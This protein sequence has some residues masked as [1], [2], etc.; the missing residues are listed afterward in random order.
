MSTAS[1]TQTGGAATVA[2]TVSRGLQGVQGIQGE[3]GPAG[4]TDYTLLTNVPATFAPSAHTHPVSDIVSI[5]SERLLGRHAG[6][7]GAGQEVTV[8]NGLEFQGSGIRRSALTGDVTASAGSN[9]TTIAN[10]AVS[11]AKLANVATATIKGR[12]TAGTGDPEDLTPAQALEVIGAATPAGAAA[13]IA[14][15]QLVESRKLRNRTRMKQIRD[16]LATAGVLDNLVWGQYFGKDGEFCAINLG[17]QLG[18][19]NR[20]GAFAIP[21]LESKALTTSVTGDC[22]IIAQ[23]A[24]TGISSNLAE[25]TLFFDSATTAAGQLGILKEAGGSFSFYTGSNSTQKVALTGA[26][27]TNGA[28]AA[29][30]LDATTNEKIGYVN[31]V[32]VGTATYTHTDLAALVTVKSFQPS[33]HTRLPLLGV[34]LFFNRVLTPTEVANV[35]TAIKK[36]QGTRKLLLDGDSMGITNSSATSQYPTKT[37]FNLHRLFSEFGQKISTVTSTAVAGT[38]PAQAVTRFPTDYAAITAG[39]GQ[40][41]PIYVAW[42]GTNSV[43]TLSPAAILTDLR[44]LWALARAR[45]Y[46][47]LAVGVVR[48]LPYIAESLA[49]NELIKADEGIYY[50]GYVDVDAEMVADFGEEYYANTTVSDGVHLKDHTAHLAFWRAMDAILH[51]FE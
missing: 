18:A 17:P 14:A 31:G 4:P 16:D 8:G 13:Q 41:A 20:A 50:D 11:N 1:V 37:P 6:G 48:K 47:V 34:C 39:T 5:A 27:T 3:V 28:V 32:N 33:A 35:T 44:A 40:V 38:T 15:N 2:V 49:L 19:E 25:F 29:G 51:L 36:N 24:S 30:T 46:V 22:T 23:I 45:G 9:A 12:I 43:D 10:D 7:S 42:T 26:N 21:T